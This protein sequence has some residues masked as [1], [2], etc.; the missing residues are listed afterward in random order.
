MSPFIR[1]GLPYVEAVLALAVGITAG[2]SFSFPSPALGFFY[3]ALATVGSGLVL[4]M[5]LPATGRAL[6]E[7]LARRKWRILAMIAVFS[8]PA[9]AGAASGRLPQALIWY[10]IPALLL[11]VMPDE[12]ADGGAAD[13]LVSRT[14]VV[15]RVGCRIAAAGILIIG[16]DLRE[17]LPVFSVFP[18]GRYELAA[19]YTGALLLMVV[20]PA[21]KGR[22]PRWCRLVFDRKMWLALGA[23]TIGAAVVIIPVAILTGFIEPGVASLGAGESIVAFIGIFLTIA[24]PEE[25]FFRHVLYGE[26]AKRVSRRVSVLIVIVLVSV[27]FGFFHWNNA[28]GYA[29]T[30]YVA[31]SALAGV[32]YGLAYHF[33]GLAAALLSHTVVDWIWLMFF[34]GSA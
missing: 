13:P 1:Y 16:L 8:L 23:T 4:A 19:L 3:G 28:V 20:L 7:W 32:A 24:L 17:S 21:A 33:G 29:Q 18:E 25:L 27:A 12:V 9:V 14:R 6:T 2:L 11:A 26:I 34:A 31:L 30:V 15:L 22:P 10:G 5:L